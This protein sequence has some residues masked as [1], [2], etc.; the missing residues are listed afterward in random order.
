[1]KNSF[2]SLPEDFEQEG[3][4][5]I[6]IAFCAGKKES[7]EQWRTDSEDT[8]NYGCI[9]SVSQQSEIEMPALAFVK[10]F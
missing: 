5:S 9:E 3:Q 1:M 7:I 2:I 6:R 10:H 8:L 4:L